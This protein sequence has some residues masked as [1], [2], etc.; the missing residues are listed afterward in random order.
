M[1]L[2][3]YRIQT[4]RTLPDLDYRYRVAREEYQTMNSLNEIAGTTGLLPYKLLETIHMILGMTSELN[5]LN[6]AEENND[7]VNI[8]EELTDILWYVSNYGALRN[9]PI[10]GYQFPQMGFSSLH[11]ISMCISE[12]SDPVK[13]FFAYR[14]DI[15]GVKR[16]KEVFCFFKLLDTIGEFANVNNINLY[17]S[18]QK[19]ID[20]LRVRFPNRFDYTKAQEDNRDLAA[21]RKTLE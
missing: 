20:K 8:A 12:I 18:M 10:D 6:K 7:K 17:E 14:T 16:E 19:N 13:K 21:E 2:Q 1:T 11:D 15:V 5:E 4:Q 9:I 3:E